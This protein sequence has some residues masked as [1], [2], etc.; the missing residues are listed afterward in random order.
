MTDSEPKPNNSNNATPDNAKPDNTKPVTPLR[1]FIG[2]SISGALGIA[3][4]SLTVAIANN[5][6]SKPM[7]SEK[8]IVLRLSSLVRTLVLGVASLGTFIFFF[9]AFGLILL[10]L[11]LALKELQQK[12]IGNKKET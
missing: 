10:A 12:A 1:C 2:S 6:A 5:F 11:Q 9:V 7:V 3:L 8:A 4:Y